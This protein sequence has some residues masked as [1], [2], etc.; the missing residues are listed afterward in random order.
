MVTRLGDNYPSC[1]TVNMW[2]SDFRRCR[3]SLEDDILP[4]RHFTETIR[5]TLI[6]CVIFHHDTPIIAMTVINECGFELV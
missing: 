2:A 1:D 5:G 4:G 3:E 6:K